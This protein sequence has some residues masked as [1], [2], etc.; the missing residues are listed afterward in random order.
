[1]N[2]IRNHMLSQL[3]KKLSTK[4]ADNVE[5]SVYNYAIQYATTHNIE[6]SWE[7]R[8][9]THVYN[10]KFCELLEKLT[11]DMIDKIENKTISARDVAFHQEV[12]IVIENDQ[13]EVQDGIFQCRKCNSRKTTY[14]SLQTRSADEPMTNFITCIICKHRWKM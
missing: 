12:D 10:L 1:M 6:K 4:K 3:K 8:L 11:P 5:K 7:E 14:Y 13:N 2:A 9:F